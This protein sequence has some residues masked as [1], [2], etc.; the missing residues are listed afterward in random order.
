MKHE[1]FFREFLVNHVDL[2]KTRIERL[3]SHVSA[4]REYLVDHL[5][6]YQA[7]ERQGS[8]ALGTIIKPVRMGQEYDAD[9]LLRMAYRPDHGAA[10]YI[11]SVYDCF[12]DH[13]HYRKITSR[14]TRCVMLDY[15]GDVHLDIVPYLS[16]NTRMYICNRLED[17]FEATDGT[18][19]RDWFNAKNRLTEGNLKRVTRLLK[20]MRDHKRNFTAPSILLTTLIGNTVDR[21]GSF[22]TVP[23][24]L[25]SVM[26]G[27]DSFLYPNIQMPVIVNPALPEEDFTRKWDQ[28]KYTNFRNLFHKYTLRVTDAFQEQDHNRSVRKWRSVFGDEFGRLRSTGS[29]PRSVSPQRPWL[30]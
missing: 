30:E 18:G 11:Q 1:Q 4:V 16:V 10:S 22:G 29:K 7:V 17:S 26:V 24:T 13:G 6:G 21:M 12:L 23:D 5:A 8:Y 25:L 27:I 9:L 28:R 14:K 3:G 19:Y 15:A 20:Y 2:N